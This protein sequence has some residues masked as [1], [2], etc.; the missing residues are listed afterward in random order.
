[1]PAIADAHVLIMATNRFEESELF[2]P[3]EMLVERGARVTLASPTR[4]QIMATV[5]DEPGRRITPDL[6]IEE[7]EPDDYDALLLPG[8]VG[9]PDH[10][11]MNRGAVELIRRF[12]EAGRPVAA[13]CHGPWLL[14]EA[15]V[16]RGRRATSWASIRTDLRNA[17]AT[18]IDQPV[19]TDGHIITS[20][21]PDDVPAFT[22]A[23]IEAIE[24]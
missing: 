19:V 2:G 14:V 7:V 23:L 4:D 17:G 18:V 16:L 6:T 21:M 15:D 3:R 24:R 22:Q 5:H 20:R 1:M 10:L 11:R 8:G 13:I 12:V 9:N